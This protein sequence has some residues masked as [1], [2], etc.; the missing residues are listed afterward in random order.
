MLQF[1]STLPSSCVSAVELFAL[2]IRVHRFHL[3]FKRLELLHIFH[4]MLIIWCQIWLE[5]V[6]FSTRRQRLECTNFICLLKAWSINIFF[7]Q[8][9]I[10]PI[11]FSN[12]SDKMLQFPSTLPSSYVSAVKLFALEIRVHKF[13]IMILSPVSNFGDQSLFQ[14]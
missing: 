3:L 6:A 11:R 7:K 5:F 4:Q 10:L 9:L 13:P 8:K 2:D 1:P 12:I 14:T